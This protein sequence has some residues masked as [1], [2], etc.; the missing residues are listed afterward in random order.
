MVRP[1][2]RS[3]SLRRIWRKTPGGRTVV[4]YERRKKY[5]VRCFICG[6]EINGIPRNKDV[7]RSNKTFKRPERLFGGVLCPSCLALAIKSAIRSS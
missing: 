7:T 4:H 2:L 1:A 3:R 5:I 6:T